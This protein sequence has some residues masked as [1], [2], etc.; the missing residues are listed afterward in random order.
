MGDGGGGLKGRHLVFQCP[1]VF[2]DKS[3]DHLFHGKVRDQL[4]LGELDP[5]DR[6]KM[7]DTLQMLFDVFALVRDAGRRDDRL[8]EDLEADF[9]A[10]EVGNL[11]FLWSK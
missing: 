9:T 6:I 5:S 8:A 2:G 10:K 11:T 1:F 3:V 4:V 7:A